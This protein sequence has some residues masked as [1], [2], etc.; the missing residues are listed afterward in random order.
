[1]KNSIR[2]LH[3]LLQIP[4]LLLA[5]GGSLALSLG[6][7]SIPDVAPPVP[8]APS[9]TEAVT[10]LDPATAPLTSAL[11]IDPAVRTGKLDNGFTYYLRHNTRPR[12][13]AQLWLVVNAGSVLEEDDQQGLAHF[14]EHMAFNGTRRFAKQELVEY[15]ESIGMRFGPDLN[16]Y[17]SFD[18]TVYMLQVPTDVDEILEKAFD[19]LEDW[20]GGVSL[21]GEEIDKERGVVMEEWRIASIRFSSPARSMPSAYRSVRPKYSRTRPTRRYGVSIATGTGPS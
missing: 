15:L 8:P 11:P 6:C 12:E 20:A 17:T 7:A 10:P 4:L 5:L 18:E 16:A 13:R 21:E 3:T 9:E 1:M 2:T 19:I 14:L